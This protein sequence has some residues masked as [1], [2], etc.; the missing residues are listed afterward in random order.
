MNVSTDVYLQDFPLNRESGFLTP[1]YELQMHYLLLL[2]VPF[3]HLQK[4]KSTN[5]RTI[6]GRE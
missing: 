3:K 2:I 6:R 4:I 1:N 5:I